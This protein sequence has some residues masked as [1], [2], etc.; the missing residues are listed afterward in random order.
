MPSNASSITLNW[1]FGDFEDELIH[2]SL[3]SWALLFINH[4]KQMKK[5]HVFSEDS[6]N[7]KVHDSLPYIL[8]YY[9][10]FLQF[11]ELAMPYFCSP[12]GNFW[13][14]DAR[15]WTDHAVM[16]LLLCMR[17]LHAKTGTILVDMT[18]KE[19]CCQIYSQSQLSWKVDHHEGHSAME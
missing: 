7:L 17:T 2:Q 10:I 8:V 3:K 18:W 11:C 13:I 12:H 19:Q 15:L 14:G 5:A 9:Y 4:S 16:T 1:S 6:K